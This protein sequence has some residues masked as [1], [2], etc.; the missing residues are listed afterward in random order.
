M[1]K[2]ARSNVKA[3]TTRVPTGGLAANPPSQPDGQPAPLETP[4]PLDLLLT[5]QVGLDPRSQ[6]AKRVIVIGAGLAGLV[7]AF[8]LRRQGHEPLVLEAQHRVGGRI[9]TLRNFAPGLYAEAGGMRI[10]RAHD[11]TLAYCD[12]FGLEL[13]PFV[14]GNP[15]GLV[16]IGGQRMTAAEADAEPARLPFEFAEHERGRSVN[17]LWDEATR[18]LREMVEREGPAAWEK[19]VARHDKDSLR[20]FLTA[21]GFSE[22]AI[23]AYGVLNFVEAELNSGVVEELREDIGKAYVDMQEIVGGMDRLPNAFYHQLQDLVRFGAEVI[24][25]DQDPHSVTVHYRTTSGRFSVTGD[26][27]VCTIPFSVLQSVEAIKPFSR[28]KQRAIRQ[29]Y[30]SA[31]TKILFQVRRRRWEEL[32]GIYGGATVTDLA[33]RRMNYPTPNPNDPRGMLLASYTWGQDAARWGAMDE[34]TRIE[35]ALED[36]ARIHPWIGEEFEVGASHAWYDDPWARGAF[37]L[38][39]PEQQTNLQVDIVKPE[40]RVHFAGEHTSLY[41]AWIQGALESGIR[42]A[43]EIHEAAMVMQPVAEG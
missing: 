42:A 15:K 22:G 43:R 35:Q 7:A 39:E 4:L 6:P 13:R 23:E 17:Q 21:K 34:E 12:L 3:A 5:P 26:Y 41:H 31:S 37:A 1:A 18:D 8:E 24:A 9:Y 29:L 16:F 19:I 25:I 40:G 11:L 32:D 28:E 36:V 27:A 20:E 2:P 30:Y 38:F 14:M 33:I 10:P